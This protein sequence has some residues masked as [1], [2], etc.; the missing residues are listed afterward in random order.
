MEISEIISTSPRLSR[1][2][3]KFSLFMQVECE[4]NVRTDFH[5]R[6]NFTSVTLVYL[7]SFKLKIQEIVYTFNVKVESGSTF[8]MLDVRKAC[9]SKIIKSKLN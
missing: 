1:L 5:C 8:T 2:F 9:S 6:V 4:M 7:T 3:E